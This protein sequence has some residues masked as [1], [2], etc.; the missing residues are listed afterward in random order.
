M[1]RLYFHEILDPVRQP[2]AHTRYLETLG[3]LVRTE[4]NARGSASN[5]CMAAWVPVFLTGRWPEIVTF[6]EMQG[7]WEGFGRH[8]DAT[9]DLFHEPLERFYGERTGGFDRVLV[10]ADYSIDRARLLAEGMRAPVVLQQTIGLEAGGASDYLARLGEAAARIEGPG[11]PR[12][13]GA[14]E[15]ALRNGSEAL[16]LWAFDD[17]AALAALQ[18]RPDAVPGWADWARAARQHERTHTGLVLR[19]ADWSPLR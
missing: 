2:G 9:P 13:F 7:G 12:L 5:G 17:F 1:Q 18:A 15:T 14:Y 4:G 19:P 6:W 8:F 11:A 10:A 3:R 16:V